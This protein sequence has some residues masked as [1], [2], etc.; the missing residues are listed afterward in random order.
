KEPSTEVKFQVAQLALEEKKPKAQD[1]QKVF[2]DNMYKAVIQAE[3][4]GLS[5]CVKALVPTTDESPAR[6]E[7]PSILSFSTPR[8]NRRANP[9]DEDRFST[10]PLSSPSRMLLSAPIDS[11]RV[12]PKTPYR[13]LDAPNILDDF[14]LNLIDWSSTNI[15]GVGLGSSVYLWSAQ[16][17]KV[18]KLCDFSSDNSVTSLSWNQKGTHLA[19]GTN[20]GVVELWDVSRSKR[21][22]QLYGPQDRVVSLAWNDHILS[23]GSR[24]YSILTRD[25]RAPNDDSVFRHIHHRQEVC[26][27]KWSP[28]QTQLASGGN[29]NCLLVW[30]RAQLAR[31]LHTFTGHE[32]AIKAIA[33]SPFQ[34]GLLVSGGGTKDRK[35]RFWNTQTGA[36][37][38]SLD[39]GSQ[40]CNLA[41]S[42]H[43]NEIVST[44]GYSLNQVV[45]WKVN[46]TGDKKI[47]TLRQQT[48]LTGHLKRVLYLAMSPDGQDIVTGAGDETLRFWRVFGKRDTTAITDRPWPPASPSRRASTQVQD[49]MAVSP[50]PHGGLGMRH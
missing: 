25:M 15:L 14:Y 11:P 22:R 42:Q 49:L 23:S 50:S 1:A 7:T 32:A 9:A 5:P 27:L 43:S 3:V 44:H 16:S 39:S 28:D 36:A 47:P 33:W 13:V 18:T 17:N 6:G 20:S 48:V 10:T 26:G 46:H 45:V 12:I 29:D 19:V 31:P 8:K 38:N 2:T 35:I 34:S 41:W 37:L 40:V 24:D 4:T 21:V 30:D